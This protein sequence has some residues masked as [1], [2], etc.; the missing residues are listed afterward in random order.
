MSISR[1]NILLRAWNSAEKLILLGGKKM[2]ITL[3][4]IYIIIFMIN[5]TPMDY[6]LWRSVIQNLAKYLVT[7]P[8]IFPSLGGS[9]PIHVFSDT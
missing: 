8:V 7:D 4:W 5:G 3:R 6:P 9:P 2:K 1:P